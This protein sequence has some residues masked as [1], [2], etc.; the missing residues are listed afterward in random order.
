MKVIVDNGI[1]KFKEASSILDSLCNLNFIYVD[2]EEITNSL[3]KDAE[4]L[5][6]RSTTKVNKSLLANTK[7]KLVGSATSGMD[8]IDSDYLDEQKIKW[9]YS[10]GC[11]ASS[12]V[13]YVLSSIALL[14]NKNLFND[15]D[16]VGIFGCGNIG[17]KLRYALKTL[18]IKNHAYDPLLKMKFL[19]S[20]EEVKKC[21]LLTLHIPYS[22]SSIFPTHNII[23]SNFLK[24]FK[25]KILINTSR[26]EV[27]DEKAL[28]NSHNLFIGDVWKNEP[29]PS[30]EMIDFSFI[31][32]PH[33]A[34]HSYEGKI[35]GTLQL[36]FNLFKYLNHSNETQDRNKK[37]LIN[38][39]AIKPINKYPQKLSEYEQSF[40]VLDESKKF[41]DA[42]TDFHDSLP[43]KIFKN[44]RL[45][46]IKRKDITP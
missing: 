9:F 23:N 15:D 36:L 40:N 38:Y 32:T 24:D 42:C 17:S 22:N 35:N 12:V 14:K 26:G 3:L 11:N 4:V 27:I 13:H 46:H 37:L 45:N 18:K 39:F 29:N 19:T 10:P 34:G 16:R 2:S 44:L 31:A 5:F 1:K 28:I 6:I 43:S 20:L 21:K 25:N 30:I 8:H 7:I 41:K 33:I